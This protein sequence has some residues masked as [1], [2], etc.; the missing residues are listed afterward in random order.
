MNANR[1]DYLCITPFFPSENEVFGSYVYDQIVAIKKLNIFNRII[2]VKPG[3]LRSAQ[4]SYEYKG[5]HVYLCPSVH[6]PSNLFNGIFNELNEDLFNRFLKKIGLNCSNIAVVHTHTA[7]CAFYA[8]AIKKLNAK[9]LTMVQHHDGDPYGIRN[10]RFSGWRRNVRYKAAKNAEVFSQIDVHICIS[11]FVER[12]LKEFP[13]INDIDY[14]E[15]YR[16]ALH[17]VQGIKG[18]E[19]KKSIILHNG[20]DTNIFVPG[21][22]E[23]G[24]DSRKFTIGCV[25]HFQK[26]KGHMTILKALRILRDEY[27]HE[28]IKVRFV[29]SGPTWEECRTF[30]SLHNLAES[31]SFKK[32]VQHEELV[33]FYQSLDLY[34]MPSYYEGFGCVYLE[35]AAC[36]V[37]FMACEGQGIEDYIPESEKSM[38]LCKPENAAQLAHMIHVYITD[39]PKQNL[40]NPIS[41]ECLVEHCFSELNRI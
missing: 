32:E 30:V 8:I 34:V 40:S 38:W 5:I 20:V 31:V 6:L 4:H 29:G 17:R 9:A 18:A 11:R 1:G 12:H 37:P 14:A 3:S 10:A 41:I 15:D 16:N 24:K 33:T 7:N 2:V 26:I 13:A 39:K 21:V 28:H 27:G 23:T 19:I 35:A 36:G 22:S 25:A